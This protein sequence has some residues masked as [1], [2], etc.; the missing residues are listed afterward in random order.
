MR[1][2]TMKRRL[3]LVTILTLAGGMTAATLAK[4]V[5]YT[6]PA[7]TATLKQTRDQGYL[8]AEGLCTACHSRDYMT[9]QPP[10]KGK[11]FWAAEVTKMVTVYGAPIPEPDRAVIAEYLAAVY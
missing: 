9:T 10:H 2:M 11:E 7:E 8:K 4:P 3:A 5:T 1:A 6:L